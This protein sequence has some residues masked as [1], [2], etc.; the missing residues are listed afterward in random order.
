MTDILLKR[1]GSVAWISCPSRDPNAEFCLRNG[2]VRGPAARPSRREEARFVGAGSPPLAAPRRLADR[3]AP[4]R[5]DAPHEPSLDDDRGWEE[6]DRGHRG[7]QTG[8]RGF[9]VAKFSQLRRPDG[10]AS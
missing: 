3:L 9:R 2:A 8:T 5:R 6:S 10:V 7:L 1:N 4:R